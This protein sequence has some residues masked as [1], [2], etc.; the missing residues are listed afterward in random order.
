MNS[1]LPDKCYIVIYSSTG[2]HLKL[3]DKFSPFR[4]NFSNL[5]LARVRKRKKRKAMDIISL[6]ER[7]LSRQS[8]SSITGFNS[9][10]RPVKVEGGGEEGPTNFLINY[11]PPLIFWARKKTVLPR[12]DKLSL[13]SNEL[14]IT[15]VT[16]WHFHAVAYSR[17]SKKKTSLVLNGYGQ[18]V[19]PAK[20]AR[21]NPL[22]LQELNVSCAALES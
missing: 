8:D 19:M 11:L 20:L 22:K 4:K 21:C 5:I 17:R 16:F 13:K 14:S 2:C 3:K 6:P 1:Q 10:N 18:F 15:V 7:Q 12:D 9:L